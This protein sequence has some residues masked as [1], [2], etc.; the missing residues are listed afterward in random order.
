MHVVRTLQLEEGMITAL[1]VK[2]KD[3][4]F[5]AD[6]G[7]S[8]THHLI[9]QINSCGI[10]SIEIQDDEPAAA[11]VPETAKAPRLRKHL[12]FQREM[13]R[14][15]HIPRE[16]RVPPVFSVSSLNIQRL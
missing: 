12:I 10:P 15:L 11:E 6:A 1:P 16:L 3:G 5:V 14:I 13:H 7:V 4:Q 9:A 8:P 2:T